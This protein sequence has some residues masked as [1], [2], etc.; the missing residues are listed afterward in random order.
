MAG[1]KWNKDQ[2]RIAQSILRHRREDDTYDINLVHEEV[3]DVGLSTITKVFKA[4]KANKWIIPPLSSDIPEPSEDEKE[5]DEPL[6]EEISGNGSKKD[7][8]KKPRGV[9]IANVGQRRQGAILFV[10]GDENIELEPRKLYDSYLYYRSIQRMVPEIDDDF[11]TAIKT[12][13]KHVWEHMAEPGASRSE[14]TIG[15]EDEG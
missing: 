11:S 8:K 6:I 3:P 9:S 4:L 13:M 10:L 15:K 2:R 7:E 1:L 12:A 5:E 14:A